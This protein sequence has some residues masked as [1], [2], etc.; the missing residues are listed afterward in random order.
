MR[1]ILLPNE[2]FRCFWRA[3][4]FMNRRWTFRL[5][6][7]T[8]SLSLQAQG[9]LLTYTYMPTSKPFPTCSNFFVT[10]CLFPCQRRE[11]GRVGPQSSL[12]S[13]ASSP[14]VMGLLQQL[15][16]LHGLPPRGRAGRRHATG[17][18]DATN[19]W[20]KIEFMVL[21]SLVKC[22]WMRFGWLLDGFL[23]IF[24]WLPLRNFVF[25]GT[26]INQEC[27]TQEV[28]SCGLRMVKMS[29]QKIPPER[30]RSLIWTPS[31]DRL[32]AGDQPS[33]FQ[34]TIL[35]TVLPWIHHTDHGSTDNHPDNWQKGLNSSRLPAASRQN[36]QG[37]LCV[38]TS[39]H[40]AP[41]S[42]TQKLPPDVKMNYWAHRPTWRKNYESPLLALYVFASCG[43]KPETQSFFSSTFQQ[44]KQG[45]IWVWP[46]KEAAVGPRFYS[47]WKPTSHFSGWL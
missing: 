22:Y 41:C 29:A 39:M 36:R 44:S 14:V 27:Q 40:K 20:P 2:V 7:E 45:P 25:V 18:R 17:A 31:C 4:S 11:G 5:C 6:A 13:S 24:C 35:S 26:R 43:E 15:S 30:R 46:I 16:D 38:R 21:G 9:V 12:L 33:G 47:I 3:V 34:L 28:K 42:W 32:K 10:S 1:Q 8:R 37:A 19:T 23:V